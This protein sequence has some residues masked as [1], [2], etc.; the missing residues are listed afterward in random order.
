MRTKSWPVPPRAIK[1]PF[2]IDSPEVIPYER[3]MA[4]KP[5]M[6]WAL[7]RTWSDEVARNKGMELEADENSAWLILD[8][9]ARVEHEG[10][11]HVA[12]SGEWMFPKPC[13]RNQSFSGNFHFL[14]VT[15]Q[16][17][18]PSGRHVFDEG[19]TRTL[20]A[21]E[22]PWLEQTAR[23]IISAVHTAAPSN[24]YYIALHSINLKAAARLFEMAG[25]WAHAYVQAM[26]QLDICPDIGQTRDPR[27]EGLL[28]NLR[29]GAP[30]RTPDRNSLAS[31][32]GVSPRQLDRMIKEAT[33]RTLA[34]NHD[35]I[36]FEAARD[37]LLEKGLRVKEVAA[38][39]GFSDLSSFSRWFT[40]HAGCSPRAYRERFSA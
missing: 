19:L 17:K 30:H 28:A 15:I 12:R 13:K 35:Q 21:H 16:W 24:Y 29:M 34:E 18:W 26:E 23:E 39:I 32:A 27:I 11:T 8:G 38:E 10:G 20:P 5:T 9:E 37:G 7:E 31:A 40:K 25:K 1:F 3:L 33:G 6:L 2:V 22:A 36:R 14:S 4:A